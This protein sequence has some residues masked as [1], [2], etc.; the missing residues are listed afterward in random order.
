[1]GVTVSE[2]RMILSIIQWITKVHS[3]ILKSPKYPNQHGWQ[4]SAKQQSMHVTEWF[5]WQLVTFDLLN[6]KKFFLTRIVLTL[7][8]SCP[9]WESRGNAIFRKSTI[10]RWQRCGILHFEKNSAHFNLHREAKEQNQCLFPKN[11]FSGAIW[12]QVRSITL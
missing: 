6:R 10:A 2:K 8:Y 3:Q 12:A 11:T 1:M 9:Q 5:L 4:E 7:E